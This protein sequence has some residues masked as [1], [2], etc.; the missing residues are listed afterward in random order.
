[1]ALAN[2]TAAHVLAN[3]NVRDKL[4]PVLQDFQALAQ[5]NSRPYKAL[6]DVQLDVTA[7]I[8]ALVD[9]GASVTPTP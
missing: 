1:M 7:L 2:T 8:D 6:A 9:A 4:I 3:Q 5:S